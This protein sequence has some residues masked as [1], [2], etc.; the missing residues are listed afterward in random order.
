MT[1]VVQQ[2]EP[3]ETLDIRQLSH[4][5]RSHICFTWTVI[6]EAENIG[7]VSSDQLVIH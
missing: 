6:T 2:L 5:I 1:G 4:N 7:K 3:K